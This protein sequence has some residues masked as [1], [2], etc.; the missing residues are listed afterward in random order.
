MRIEPDNIYLGDAKELMPY[1]ESESCHL[2]ITDP[3]YRVTSRGSSKN[4]MGGLYK[5]DI[6]NK[7]KIFLHNDIKPLEYFPEFYRI[8]A[9][10]AHCYVMTNNLN[11]VNMLNTGIKSGF[12]FV[13]SIIWNKERKI[14]GRYYMGQYE[15]I[16]LFRKGKDKPINNMGDSDI[17]TIKACKLKGI[18]GKN[19]HDTEK[20]QSLM[21]VLILNSS[22]E[23]EIVVDPFAGYG[24]T[25]AGA[26]RHKRKYIAIEIDPIN[27]SNMEKRIL[28]QPLTYQEQTLF[29]GG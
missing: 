26:K 12:R 9:P 2:L 28:N 5:K 21:E 14:S 25:P 4:T 11:L 17:I 6:V 22:L 13:K 3:P 19:I 16:L 24:A 10:D 29:N 1:I 18:D 20:P 8:L 7:G 15:H 27:Y 23:G